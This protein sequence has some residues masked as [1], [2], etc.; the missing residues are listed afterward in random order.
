MVVRNDY[1]RLLFNGDQGVVANVRSPGGGA[2]LKAV[3]LRNNQYVAFHLAALRQSLELSYATTI[4]K[5]QG[6]EF[7]TVAI[8]LPDKDL[9]ILTRELL[10]TAVSRARSSVVILGDRSI[11]TNAIA[12]K[13]ERFSG[14]SESLLSDSQS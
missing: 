13:E 2:T 11:L 3:F 10:Y 5:A 14:L 4:H 6:S 7:E 9:P 12:R 8:V 1:E